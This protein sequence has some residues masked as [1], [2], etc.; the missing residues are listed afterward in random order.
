MGCAHW[1]L[2]EVAVNHGLSA[3]RLAPIGRGTRRHPGAMPPLWGSGGHLGPSAC[4]MGF[5]PIAIWLSAR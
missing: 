1:L 2:T 4:R 5:G 3:C